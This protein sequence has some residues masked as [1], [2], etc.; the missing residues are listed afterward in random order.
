VID[1]GLLEEARSES[2]MPLTTNGATASPTST[3]SRSPAPPSP[4]RTRRNF[5]KDEIASHLGETRT[6]RATIMRNGCVS[7][8]TSKPAFRATHL[9]DIHNAPGSACRRVQ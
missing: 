6:S 2:Q 1:P 9:Q 5:T 8:L 3:R 4:L 7:L